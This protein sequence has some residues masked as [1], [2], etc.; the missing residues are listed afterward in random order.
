MTQQI[1]KNWFILLWIFGV[2]SML[3]FIFFV[4]AMPEKSK[5]ATMTS[6]PMFR[7][8]NFNGGSLSQ[9]KLYTYINGTTTPKKT[10]KNSS[11]TSAHTNPII[12]NASGRPPNDTGIFLQGRYT[13][14]LKDPNDAEIWS[15]D[16]VGGMG[17]STGSGCFPDYNID[18]QGASGVTASVRNCIDTIIGTAGSD[19][20]T[21]ILAHNSGN[22][23][24]TYTFSTNE[25]LPENIK[26]QVERGAVISIASGR[27]F[28]IT[29]PKQLDLA[30]GQTVFTTT[31]VAF[32]NRGVILPDWWGSTSGLTNAV[33]AAGSSPMTIKIKNI[34]PIE[35]SVSIPA[36]VVLSF[37]YGG[38]LNIDTTKLVTVNTPGS[39][40]AGEYQIFT[41]GGALTWSNPGTFKADWWASSKTGAV[42]KMAIESTR[43]NSYAEGSTITLSCG[44]WA[45]GTDEVTSGVSEIHLIG[46]GWDDSTG[47]GTE[48]TYSGTTE[49][50]LTLIG[51]SSVSRMRIGA[52]G[53]AH[54]LQL[55]SSVGGWQGVVRDMYIT[56]ANQSG[57]SSYQITGGKMFN[58]YSRSNAGAG[59]EVGKG[60]NTIG[61]FYS[62]NF[63][64][65]GTQGVIYQDT[66][67]FRYYGCVFEGNT[68]EAIKANLGASIDGVWIGNHFEDNQDGTVA[69]FH[70]DLS[71]LNNSNTLIGNT[72]LDPED[73]S[74]YV[75]FGGRLYIANNTWNDSSPHITF[76]QTGA[77]LISNDTQIT[78]AQVTFNATTNI[79]HTGTG[80]TTTI[81]KTTG[82]SLQ[83]ISYPGVVFTNKGA[84]GGVVLTLPTLLG[85]RSPM[86]FCVATA[87]NFDINPADTDQI[88]PN[89]THAGDA[90]RSAT[91]GNCITL[92]GIDDTTWGVQGE[93]GTWAD[94]D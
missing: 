32:T 55:G 80:L 10:Y 7:E 53:G 65:N 41:G 35:E 83:F 2:V 6:N 3:G 1:K 57:I 45:F 79:F 62:C 16:G 42:L 88:L 71:H 86:S 93:S 23:T 50:A 44:T 25:T 90:I 63:D 37:D 58:V 21:I 74:D 59:M 54:G 40:D 18:D 8:F 38:M 5:A 68:L 13:F 60:T 94:V 64:N 46:C 11:G 72:F 22:D 73:D 27:T 56:G 89:T 26:L 61:S 47:T 4:S 75:T 28:T 76:A 30:S 14:I 19:E 34:L 82:E 81:A 52:S 49:S 70:M 9:G 36:T 29:H 92:H 77:V 31:G 24:T 78:P 69:G 15:L 39:I 91:I 67:K 48:I 84:S 12:L 85:S 33:T 17:F 66:G 87:Q 43:A 20:G 51:R